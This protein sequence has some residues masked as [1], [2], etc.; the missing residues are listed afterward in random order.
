MT[1]QLDTAWNVTADAV[2][3]LTGGKQHELFGRYARLAA[4][5]AMPWLFPLLDAAQ[6]QVFTAPGIFCFLLPDKPDHWFEV[7]EMKNLLVLLTWN[8]DAE[9]KQ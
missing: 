9:I 2:T 1:A 5:D 4:E 3:G 6:A 8:T 7:P